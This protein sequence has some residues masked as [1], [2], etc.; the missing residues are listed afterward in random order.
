[1]RDVMIHS[2][3]SGVIW[4]AIAIILMM[5]VAGRVDEVGRIAWG[6][7][8]G[9]LAAPFIGIG[10]GA[11]W[12][13]F[14]DAGVG[15]R[16]V[17]SLATLYLAAFLFMLAAGVTA[18]AAGEMRAGSLSRVFVDSWNAAIAGLTWTGFVLVVGPLAF[19]N[20]LWVSRVGT[21]LAGRKQAAG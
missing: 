18:F 17:L 7:R 2:G 15:W 1:M 11:C 16:I 19:L 8:G 4:A 21:A 9:L 10:V 20:H 12:R 3:I 5:I 14:S 6:L 13:T